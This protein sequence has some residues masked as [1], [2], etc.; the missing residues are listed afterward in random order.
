MLWGNGIAEEHER[1]R[2]ARQGVLAQV[3]HDGR[4]CEAEPHLRKSQGSVFSHVDKVADD[5]KAEAEPQ[6]VALNF[7]D[8]DQR[9]SSQSTLEI[10]ETSCL[11]VDRQGVPARAFATRA[12][13]LATR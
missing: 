11:F 6:S 7:R 2:E 13:H 9:R 5:R 1:K 8:A 3:R 12:E 4:R 10:N